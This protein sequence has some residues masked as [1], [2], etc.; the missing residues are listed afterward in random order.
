MKWDFFAGRG[1]RRAGRREEASPSVSLSLSLSFYLLQ[2]YHRRLYLS[3]GVPSMWTTS[4]VTIDRDSP[5][6]RYSSLSLFIV[7]L[8]VPRAMETISLLVRSLAC[9]FARSMR[10]S[11]DNRRRI[12]LRDL[13]FCICYLFV[14]LRARDSVCTTILLINISPSQKKHQLWR[15]IAPKQ[16]KL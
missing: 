6:N 7:V 5:T 2:E 10:L 12:G 3:R 11:G 14:C 8:G 15:S 1:V 4:R 16:L 13:R 9:W